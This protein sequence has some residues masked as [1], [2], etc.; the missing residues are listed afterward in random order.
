M[1]RVKDAF[2]SL[3]VR[4]GFRID[5]M[6][7]HEIIERRRMSMN[8]ARSRRVS[9]RA[10]VSDIEGSREAYRGSYDA[11]SCLCVILRHA[12]HL[13]ST[14]RYSFDICTSSVLRDALSSLSYSSRHL[15]LFVQRVNTTRLHRARKLQPSEHV[16]ASRA[17]TCI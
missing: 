8:N 16:G 11:C 4:L 13:A 15:A 10:S 14:S 2:V 6:F 5:R 7:I 17:P 12:R 3:F 9:S 1:V